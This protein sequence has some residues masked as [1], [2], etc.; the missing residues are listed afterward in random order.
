MSSNANFLQQLEHGKTTPRN[1]G[2]R[3][4]MGI[5]L[6]ASAM[7]FA[8]GA[9]LS[10]NAGNR[11]ETDQV[12]AGE[13]LQQA[14]ENREVFSDSFV[15]FR[16]TLRVRVD[17]ALMH[18]TCTFRMPDRL[19]VEMEDGKLP[20]AVEATIRSM[21]MHRVP[22]DRDSTD[23]AVGY[24]AV[25]ADP[26]GRQIMMADSYR[27]A[28]RIRDRQILKVSRGFGD[29]SR[30]VLNVMETETTVSGRYLPRHVL[31]VRFDEE[32]GAIQEAWSYLSKFQRLGG[33]YL[34][35]SRQVVRAG[36]GDT[37]ATL[38]EWKDVELLDAESSD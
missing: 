36:K 38:I 15:G 37:G 8:F 23:E 16:S 9:L 20:E 14:R 6:L 22:S 11:A 4:S 13:L 12:T 24:A 2:V 21:L 31:A 35:L 10:L 7:I 5:A 1:S 27:S 29:N 19:E 17:G 33:D 25:D 30:L 3:G 32:T 26:M 18:G 28:Y 34:P